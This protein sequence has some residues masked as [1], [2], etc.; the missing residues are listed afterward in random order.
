MKLNWLG[1]LVC[2]IM[3]A[4]NNFIDYQAAEVCA[5]HD[6]KLDYYRMQKFINPKHFGADNTAKD[7]MR[8][9][10]QYAETL[11]KT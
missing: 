5:R 10:E 1:E 6:K 11:I 7:N 9:L 2:L 8:A 3:C 4:S